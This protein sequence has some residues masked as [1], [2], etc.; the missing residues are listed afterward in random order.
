MGKIKE[1]LLNVEEEK[2]CA[3]IPLLDIIYVIP[4]RRK[5]DSGYNCMEIIG[6]NADGYKKK[7]ASWSD[8]FDISEIFGSRHA[9]HHVS[10]DIPEYGVM[11]FFVNQFQFKVIHH[12]ISSFVVDLVEREIKELKGVDKE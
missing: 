9:F 7:L 10:M 8:V 3:D 2:F 5:H 12:G 6:S 4:T 11:R 1:E